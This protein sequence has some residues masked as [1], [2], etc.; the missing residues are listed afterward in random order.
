MNKRNILIDTDP[1]V[2]DFFC[3]MMAK[4]FEDVFTIRALT[5]VCGNNTTDVCTK[6]A[7]DS[8][9]LL[10]IDAKIAKG[11]QSYLQEPYG[12]VVAGKPG[13][14]G[15]GQNGMAEAVLPHSDQQIDPL[16]AW[17]VIYNEAVACG[18][19]LELV[20]VGPL[21]NI[22]KAIQKYPDLK[23]YIK[24]ITIMGGSTKMSP[25]A[26]RGESNIFHD[27][28]AA[29]VVFKSGIPITMVGL[30]ITKACP[31]R[32]EQSFEHMN[33]MDQTLADAVKKMILYRLGDPLHD[34]IA[35]GLML[36]PEMATFEEHYVWV[37]KTTDGLLGD[38][39]LDDTLGFAPN[40]RVAMEIDHTQ[41]DALFFEMLDRFCNR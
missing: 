8:A 14:G 11:G 35:V 39:I 5:T 19:D 33:G 23:K 9:K 26:T 2:D 6:N 25:E 28:H 40:I 7:L 21:T 15:H 29:D 31:V 10:G 20:P 30:N 3:L 34:A 12:Q 13:V 1:G 27:V 22:A 32:P 37:N 16:P 4:A 18:G 36:R 17:D 24:H 41:Y 38:T